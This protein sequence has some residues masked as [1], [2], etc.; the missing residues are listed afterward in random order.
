VRGAK[1][2]KVSEDSPS[3]RMEGI[4]PGWRLAYQDEFS[5]GKLCYCYCWINWD[6]LFERWRLWL[7]P[8]L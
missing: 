7:N 4:V 3:D 2:N 1:K 8:A 5:W 6:G